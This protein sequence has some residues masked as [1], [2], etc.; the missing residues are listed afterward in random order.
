M[1]TSRP[2]LMSTPMVEAILGGRKTETRR[3]VKPDI[4]NILTRGSVAE[5]AL[6]L[7]EC[8]Y[9]KPGDH[10]WLREEFRVH[11]LRLE[12][13]ETEF[14]GPATAVS[15]EYRAGGHG[16]NVELADSK[17]INQAMRAMKHDGW[18]PGMYLPRWASRLSLE[19][20]E[21]RA[22]KLKFISQNGVLAE[23]LVTATKCGYIHKWGWKGLPWDKWYQGG[24][25]EA[26]A[27]LWDM[28]N[29]SRGYPWADNPW[30]YVLV[31]KRIE[32]GG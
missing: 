30:V 3:V 29:A 9:G 6:I 32:T 28:L 11:D 4:A 2:L 16:L 24:A 8:P 12:R 7:E 10:L 15:V 17:E 18:R 5:R 31:F 1:P 20:V 23:G 21:I 22:E 25:V 13:G 26:F 14:E 19:I 27:A